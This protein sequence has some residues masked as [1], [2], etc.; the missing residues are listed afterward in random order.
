MVKAKDGC[1]FGAN[2]GPFW[3]FRNT[4]KRYELVL[5]VS[6]LAVEVLG[7]KSNGYRDIL[8]GAVASGQSVSVLYKFDGHRYQETESGSQP[9][10]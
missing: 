10:D 5:S 8:A 2:I 9:I 6:A 4:G 3:V 7:A 1:L